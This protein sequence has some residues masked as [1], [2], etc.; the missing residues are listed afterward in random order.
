MVF[1]KDSR[2][3]KGR[4]EITAF[5]RRRTIALRQTRC[6]ELEW[7]E[8]AGTGEEEFIA[9]DDLNSPAIRLLLQVLLESEGFG[10]RSF[11]EKEI[12]RTSL[13]TKINQR[14]RRLGLAVV[15]LRKK[16]SPPAT[17]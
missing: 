1:E 6:G 8:D 5:R 4:V 3:G 10:T 14:L 9:T 7:V 11:K 12:N 13:Y 16:F 2:V 15:C 17:K